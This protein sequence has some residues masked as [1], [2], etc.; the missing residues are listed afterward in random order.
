MD[1]YEPLDDDSQHNVIHGKQ[2][3]RTPLKRRMGVQTYDD[4]DVDVNLL[5]LTHVGGLRSLVWE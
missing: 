4:D 5:L 1:K 3:R 2:Q